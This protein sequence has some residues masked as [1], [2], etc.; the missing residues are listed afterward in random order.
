VQ[1]PLRFATHRRFDE[2]LLDEEES[3]S[4]DEIE[5][6]EQLRERE[7]LAKVQEKMELANSFFP[8][9]KLGQGQ[10][11]LL[12]TAKKTE[13]MFSCYYPP[14]EDGSTPPLT[15]SAQSSTLHLPLSTQDIG[16][17]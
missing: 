7:I 15:L 1:T 12:P 3:N 5:H 17:Q 9:A 8:S 13:N 11:G 2:N 6:Y 14:V 4:F 16:T 10:L